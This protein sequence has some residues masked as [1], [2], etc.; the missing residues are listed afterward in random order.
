MTVEYLQSLGLVILKLCLTDFMDLTP[1]E[2]DYMLYTYRKDKEVDQTFW[3]GQFR[4]INLFT[5]NSTPFLKKGVTDASKLYPLSF[6][7]QIKD[8]QLGKRKIT[9]FISKDE[10]SSLM[11][12]AKKLN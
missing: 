1:V 3:E 5:H 2:F 11:D 8:E 9:P 4:L 10:Y 6:E 12:F 7:Q